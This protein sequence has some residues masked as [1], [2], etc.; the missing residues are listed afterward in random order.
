MNEALQIANAYKGTIGFDVYQC[1][2][3]GYWEL[4]KKQDESSKQQDKQTSSLDE[5]VYDEQANANKLI[6]RGWLCLPPSKVDELRKI[7]NGGVNATK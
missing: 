4:K 5:F 2:C 1:S 6:E 3:C 7:M